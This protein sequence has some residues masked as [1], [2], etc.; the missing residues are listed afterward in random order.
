MISVILGSMG[1]L[2]FYIKNMF[3]EKQNQ[4]PQQKEE[5]EDTEEKRERTEKEK[6][7]FAKVRSI[8]SR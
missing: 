7:E 2:F 4:T 5:E 8:E 6:Q 3:L 1:F